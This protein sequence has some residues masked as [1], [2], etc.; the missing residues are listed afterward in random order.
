VLGR[1]YAHRLAKRQG[2]WPSGGFNLSR[3]TAIG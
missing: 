1:D 2:Y 3:R